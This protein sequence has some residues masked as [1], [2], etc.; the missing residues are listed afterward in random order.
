MAEHRQHTRLWL[1]V[2]SPGLLGEVQQDRLPHDG[3]EPYELG[4]LGTEDVAD[5]DEA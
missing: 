4:L 5:Q 3:G 2:W 1:P